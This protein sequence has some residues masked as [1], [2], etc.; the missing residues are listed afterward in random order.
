MIFG[1][2]LFFAAL[3]IIVMW[4]SVVSGYNTGLPDIL[5]GIFFTIMICFL[6]AL[7][8]ILIGVFFHSST[9]KEIASEYKEKGQPIYSLMINSQTEGN[10][11]LG[12]GSIQGE[13]HYFYFI[14]N[15][16]GGFQRKSWPANCATIYETAAS[17][18]NLEKEQPFCSWHIIEKRY[19]PWLTW[20]V[21]PGFSG[22]IK[23]YHIE[24]IVP[25]GT[26][27]QKFEV[28]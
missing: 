2:I 10:F 14:K 11:V 1:L 28:K 9:D 16:A 15:E 7:V 17:T 25:K 8:Y 18:E 24:L 20:V 3:V 4:K 23:H 22:T 13:E 5:F 12:S 27:I 6:T 19:K 21:G 26:I